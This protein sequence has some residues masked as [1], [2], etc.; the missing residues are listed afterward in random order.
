MM[1]YQEYKN[2]NHINGSIQQ[3]DYKN[4]LLRQHKPNKKILFNI[5][6][7]VKNTVGIIKEKKLCDTKK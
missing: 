3:T 1:G 7:V 2:F 5:L 6:N 4:F